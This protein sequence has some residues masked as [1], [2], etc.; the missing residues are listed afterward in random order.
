MRPRAIV[1]VVDAS[2]E[3]ALENKVDRSR[4]LS[5]ESAYQMVSMLEDVMGRGT[6]AAARSLGVDFPAAGKTGTTDGFKDAWFVG[7]SPSL[8]VGV[9]VGFDQ[10]A[11]I[12]KNAYGARIALPIWAEFMT[13][14]AHLIPPG[15][16]QVPASLRP[17]PL[18]S[19]SYLRARGDCPAYTEYF[20][21][22]DEIPSQFCALHGG[23]IEQLAGRAARGFF[24]SLGRKLRGLFRRR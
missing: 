6:G 21:D 23:G 9:W 5:Q 16:F 3:A 4:V 22:G 24:T 11:P 10:P 18:C 1:R 19:L 7:F 15:E 8:V 20:K 13:H 2:G 14:A 12:G 17:V